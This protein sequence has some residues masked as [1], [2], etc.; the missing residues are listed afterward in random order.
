MIFKDPAGLSV[1]D[2]LCINGLMANSLT[3]VS[4]SWFEDIRDISIIFILQLSL[5]PKVGS[6]LFSLVGE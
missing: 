2:L 1:A 4:K 6:Y 3:L 5:L